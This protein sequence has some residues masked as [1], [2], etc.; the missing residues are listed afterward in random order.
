MIRE[1]YV[2]LMLDTCAFNTAACRA[3][4]LA[5]ELNYSVKRGAGDGYSGVF[6]WKYFCHFTILP[7]GFGKTVCYAC[8]PN[9][10]DI[11]HENSTPNWSL[12]LLISPVTALMKDQERLLHEHNISSGHLGFESGSEEYF[13][14]TIMCCTGLLKCWFRKEDF[15]KKYL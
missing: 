6:K 7:T 1:S 9:T 10:Y 8:L 2:S 15:V 12:F 5:T 14:K 3:A 13:M 4:F 11:L